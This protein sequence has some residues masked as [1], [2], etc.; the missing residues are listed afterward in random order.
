MCEYRALQ[1]T[2]YKTEICSTETFEIALTEE[3]Q[4][5]WGVRTEREPR[6]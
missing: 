3:R 2:R 6:L 4:Q 5:I 1:D